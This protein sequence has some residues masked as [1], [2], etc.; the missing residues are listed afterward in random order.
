MYFKAISPMTLPHRFLVSLHIH[1]T[2]VYFGFLL[3]PVSTAVD[4]GIAALHRDRLI[5]V[6]GFFW[7]LLRLLIIFRPDTL[8]FLTGEQ[9]SVFFGDFLCLASFLVLLTVRSMPLALCFQMLLRWL[10]SQPD[11][12][13]KLFREEKVRFPVTSPTSFVSFFPQGNLC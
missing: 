13:R 1:D 5:S 2:T 4:F 11:K 3:V 7:R 12:Q 6:I 10:W 8:I 9:I